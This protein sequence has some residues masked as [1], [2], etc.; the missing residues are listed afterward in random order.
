MFSQNKSFFIFSANRTLHFLSQN[1]QKTK[2]PSRNKFLTFQEM[3]LSRPKPRKVSYISGNETQH[4]SAQAKKIKQST[5]RQ[6]LIRQS[7]FEKTSYIF[8][9]GSFF[10]I[11]GNGNLKNS[12]YFRKRTTEKTSYIS[13]SNF[14]SSK[15]EKASYISGNGT[16]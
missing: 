16:F 8:S 14:Q 10:Y 4:L 15:N 13:G 6:F 11:S 5:P 12:L 3:E 2:N 7:L 1:P 9:K